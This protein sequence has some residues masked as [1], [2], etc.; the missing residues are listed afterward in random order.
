MNQLTPEQLEWCEQHLPEG[1]WKVN[2]QGLV[3]VEGNVDLRMQKIQRLPVNFGKVSGHFD[4]EGCKQLETLEGSPREVGFYFDCQG[5]VSLHSLKGAPQQV[6]SSFGCSYCTGL[7]TLE[8]APRHVGDSFV[9]RGCTGLLN[10]K[11]APQS[12]GNSFRC[13]ECTG[14]PEWVH[15][16]ADDFSDGKITWEELLQTHDKFLRKPKLGQAKNLG[17]F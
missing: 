6:N 9:C 13:E 14:L 7:Q 5:C 2:S 15:S 3:D 12:V 10:L 17:L 4:I 16:L 8:G 1:L 11:S